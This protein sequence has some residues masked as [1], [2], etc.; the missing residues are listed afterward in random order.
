MKVFF[1]FSR[2]GFPQ[3]KDYF[4]TI[5]QHIVH[6]GHDLVNDLLA[7][8]KKLGVEELPEEIFQKIRKSV[9]LSDCVVIEAS[10]VGLSLGYILTK[11]ISL[12]KPVLFLRHKKSDLK[13][14]RFVD[15]IDS[16]LLKSY[17]YT[18]KKDLK[19]QLEHFFQHNKHIKT[20]FNL[21]IPQ[22]VDSYVT[23]RSKQKGISKTQFIL[24][25]IKKGMK[26]N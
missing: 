7:E 19:N 25:E 4:V 12:N 17:I 1:E 9:S 3:Y 14:S 6:E 20:R 5:H 8:T 11:T 13:R 26:S 18:S 23:A 24:R 21:V 2:S 22:R 10:V 16:K 15:S